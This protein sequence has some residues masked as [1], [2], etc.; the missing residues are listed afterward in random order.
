MTVKT[1]LIP[2]ILCAF[3]EA[4]SSW[5]KL[6]ACGRKWHRKLEAYATCFSNGA[7][8]LFQEERRF[9]A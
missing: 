9:T 2:F 1:F 6:P 7:K 3:V 8:C 4:W 5:R